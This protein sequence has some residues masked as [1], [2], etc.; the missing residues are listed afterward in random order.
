VRRSKREA[1]A[2]KEL[3]RRRVKNGRKDRRNADK[4]RK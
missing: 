1:I 2:R 3:V 4:A